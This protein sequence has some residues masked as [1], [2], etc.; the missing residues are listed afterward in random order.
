MELQ[1][2]NGWTYIINPSAIENKE[3]IH[4]QIALPNHGT[5]GKYLFF[6]DNKKELIDLAK[7]ILERAELYDAKVPMSDVPNNSKGF[8]FVLCVYDYK[9]RFSDGMDMYADSTISYRYWKSDNDTI[10]GKYSK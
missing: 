3:E 9:N 8:G 6:S 7:R 5:I 2:K 1:N 10:K 4:K